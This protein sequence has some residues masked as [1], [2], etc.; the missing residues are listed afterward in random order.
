MTN[1]YHTEVLADDALTTLTQSAARADN[2]SVLKY[3]VFVNRIFTSTK[4]EF[5]VLVNEFNK[6]VKGIV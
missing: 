1:V 4:Q 5:D 6:F 3:D 2:E